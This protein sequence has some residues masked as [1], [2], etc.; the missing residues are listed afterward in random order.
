MRY[1]DKDAVAPRKKA[2][3]QFKER[4]YGTLLLSTGPETSLGIVDTTMLRTL[5]DVVPD[6]AL[7]KFL[8]SISNP[9]PDFE[10]PRYA[11]WVKTCR[12]KLDETQKQF[13]SRLRE[14]GLPLSDSDI[15]NLE[16]NLRKHHYGVT[17]RR[18]ITDAI[19][20]L[21]NELNNKPKS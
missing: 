15:G 4:I 21:Y 20:L 6:E 13:A 1:A 7:S 19:Q 17:R 3:S 12:A 8:S 16:N 14:R 2:Y 9:P 18:E 10:D 11:S 5:L